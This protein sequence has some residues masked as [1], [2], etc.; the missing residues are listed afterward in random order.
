M[1]GCLA[2]ILKKFLAIDHL[3]AKVVTNNSIY[4]SYVNFQSGIWPFTLRKKQPMF[5]DIVS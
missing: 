1:K 5:Q 2:K 4:G 3:T